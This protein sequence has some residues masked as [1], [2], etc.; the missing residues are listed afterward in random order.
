MSNE[1]ITKL[2][3]DWNQGN[4]AARDELIPLVANELRRIASRYLYGERHEHTLQ[5]TA[6]INEAYIRLVDQKQVQWQNRA[7]FFGV[8]AQL[9]RR[10][11]VDYA[12]TRNA[13]KRD[14]QR[15]KL[16]LDDVINLSEEHDKNLV[17]LDEALERLAKLQPQ[18]S[19]IVELR[20]FGGMTIEETASVLNVSVDTV[21]AEWRL[22]KAWLYREISNLPE[23]SE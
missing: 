8:A 12:R 23:G 5:A 1:D 10:I 19:Q 18:R 17:A 9:M 6:L 4:E 3:V 15:H 7:H 16:S 21:K 14:G 2:L 20:F 13:A 11:L 22:A